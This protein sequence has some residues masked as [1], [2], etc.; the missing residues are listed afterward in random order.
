ML[1]LFLLNKKTLKTINKITLLFFG[2]LFVSS[3]YADNQSLT[4]QILKLD[5]KDFNSKIKVIEEISKNESN[6][7]LLALKSIL[8]G[9]LFIRKSDKKINN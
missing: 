9:K 3:L 7:N 6:L 2:L 1:R 4:E 5:T 8:N